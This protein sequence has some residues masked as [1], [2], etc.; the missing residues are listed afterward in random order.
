MLAALSF[1]Q[2]RKLGF[3]RRGQGRQASRLGLS[4]GLGQ[5]VHALVGEARRPGLAPYDEQPGAGGG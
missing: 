5:Q 3:G 4:C 2:G 1:A